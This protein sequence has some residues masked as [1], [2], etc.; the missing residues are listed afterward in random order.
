MN[1]RNFSRIHSNQERICKAVGKTVGQGL[2]VII[3]KTVYNNSLVLPGDKVGD[4]VRIL[5][6]KECVQVN[7]ELFSKAEHDADRNLGVA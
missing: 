3:C 1:H 7:V 2:E 6:G 5:T 4:M